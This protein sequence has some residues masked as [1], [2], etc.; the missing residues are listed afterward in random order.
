M[1]SSSELSLYDTYFYGPMVMAALA[2]HGAVVEAGLKSARGPNWKADMEASMGAFRTSVEASI[3][4]NEEANAA[5]RAM[6]D[7]QDRINPWRR[8][9]EGF[10]RSAA[11]A[12]QRLLLRAAG[13]G[14]GT[15][16]G[17]KEAKDFLLNVA[18]LVDINKAAFSQLGADADLLSFPATAR[19]ALEGG[20]QNVAKEKG[21]ATVARA[22]VQTERV[23]LGTWLRAVE[24]A[25]EMAVQ[26]GVFK[27]DETARKAA[28]ALEAQLHAA[29]NE[30]RV[31][32]RTKAA[33]APVPPELVVPP[34][35]EPGNQG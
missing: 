12:Q 29:L 11:P 4:E 26:L 3:R 18:A 28:E 30:A 19:N 24:N 1:P 9:M 7:V 35:V 6:Q 2:N 17:P 15:P 16:R 31:Q 14:L 20:A 22:N 33:E 10:A 13:F 8:V 23:K 5:T 34:T 25:S 27:K 32:A 21:E